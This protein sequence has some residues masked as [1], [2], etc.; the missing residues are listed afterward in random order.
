MDNDLRAIT[1]KDKNATEYFVFFHFCL[2]YSGRARVCRSKLTVPHPIYRGVVDLSRDF[3][4]RI[5]P[6]QVDELTCYWAADPMTDMKSK[7]R[8]PGKHE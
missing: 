7:A 3:E 1:Y 8:V 6:E 4:P 2:R 5:A